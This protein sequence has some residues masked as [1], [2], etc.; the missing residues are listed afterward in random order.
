M[1][2]IILL[3]FVFI[4]VTSTAQVK[5]ARLFS[6]H[7]VLQRQ[8]PIPVWGWAKPGEKIKA[9]LAGQTQQTKADATGKWLVRFTALEAG[10]P[11]QLQVSG[12]SGNAAVNDILIGEVWLCSGQSN[13]EW[14]V[15]ASNHYQEEK[16]DS[17]YP[18]IRHFRVEHNVTLTPEK[19]LDK[20]EWKIASA[21]TVGGF[22]AVGFFFA[23]ELYQKLKVPVGLLHSSWGGSQIE[24]WISKEGM[25]TNDGLRSYA[26]NLPK[27][28]E[29]ADVI[30]DTKLRKQLFKDASYTPSAAEELIYVSGN[31]DLTRWQKTADP[32]GQWD[33]KGLMGFR[34]RGY[35]AREVDIPADFVAKQTILSLAENDSPNRIYINGK[36]ISEGI[37]KGSRKITVPADTWKSGKNQLVMAL[38]NHEKLSWFGPGLTG[39]A[40]D[41]YV[42]ESGQKI[43]LAGD[44]KLMPS[45]AEKHVYAHLM[46]NVGTSI[47]NAMIVPLLPFAIR[48]S[49]WYQGESNAGRAYQYRQSFPLM[50]NDWRR[51]W[52]DDFSFYWAQLSSYGPE[53]NSNTG[54][55]WA[56]LREA[57]DMT[58]SLPKT[59][60][61][62]ITDIGNP[63]D[64]HPTNKQ[65]VG[66]RLAVNALKLDYGMN[67]PYASPLYDRSEFSNGKAVISF[68]NA[69]KGLMVKDKYGYLKGFEIAGDDKVFHFAQAEIDGSKVI[70]SH[71]KVSKPVAVRYAWS[72]SPIDAN[73]YNTDGFPASGFRTDTWPGITEKGKFE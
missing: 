24:G 27:T 38:G 25:L 31:A 65:D 12:K 71:P 57:Q 18:Q 28:W 47:Y 49:L 20:G 54:S 2:Q 22:T 23:R 37:I 67:I 34:G 33:W 36:L 66:H 73:L 8:K 53:N 11:H 56:E 58:L 13:M 16:K 55:N 64:I 19:D 45:F 69:E 62:V 51:L 9:T 60:M 41:L 14:P 44:W 61:A 6:D 17:D 7:V 72:D 42:E 35:M 26:Q 1:K 30:M 10:G 70:V 4:H 52:G 48:G 32:I 63:K 21:E 68:K 59:G 46:N 40:N 39:S 43:S 29:E 3:L 15:A 50:I 5:L